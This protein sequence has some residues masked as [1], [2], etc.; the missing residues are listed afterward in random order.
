MKAKT[1]L[2]RELDIVDERFAY[3]KFDDEILYQRLRIK[4]QEE[5]NLLKLMSNLFWIAA[6]KLVF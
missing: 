4:K 2:E 5:S 3:G 1:F 6:S